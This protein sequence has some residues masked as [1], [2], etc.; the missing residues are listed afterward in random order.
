M[1][2]TQEEEVV[3]PTILEGKWTQRREMATGDDSFG[4][5][6]PKRS[7]SQGNAP[8]GVTL[9][10]VHPLRPCDWVAQVWE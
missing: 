6:S 3:V 7:P 4:S 8:H 1:G 5:V 10:G 2:G 9:Q